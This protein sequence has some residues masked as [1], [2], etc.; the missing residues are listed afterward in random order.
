MQAECWWPYGSTEQVVW[1]GVGTSLA[2]AAGKYVATLTSSDETGHDYSAD[3][4]ML[5]FADR[6][7]DVLVLTKNATDVESRLKWGPLVLPLDGML[8]QGGEVFFKVTNTNTTLQLNLSLPFVLG[9]SI[10][11]DTH[12]RLPVNVSVPPDALPSAPRIA[13]GCTHSDPHGA[14]CPTIRVP[15]KATTDW[16]DVG[17]LIDVFNHGQWGIISHRPPV[18]KSFR[19]RALPFP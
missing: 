13:S 1:E 4:G 18:E 16:I 19:C 7:L 12:I 6:N 10:Y 2:L 15:P 14:T 3:P 9:H 8:S 5:A 17:Y 11:W